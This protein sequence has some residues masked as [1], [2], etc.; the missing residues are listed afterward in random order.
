MEDECHRPERMTLHQGNRKFCLDQRPV[1]GH[2]GAQIVDW[3]QGLSRGEG[4]GST[5]G[6]QGSDK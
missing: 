3:D 4:L 1:K 6:S 5:E 2:L